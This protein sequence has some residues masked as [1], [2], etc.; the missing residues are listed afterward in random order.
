M[1]NLVLSNIRQRPTRTLISTSGVALGV[2]LIILNTGL[3]RGLLNDRIRREQGV[4]AEIQFF[5]MGG[6]GT[7]SAS[8]AMPLDV[9]YADRLKKIPGVKM[10]SPFGHYLQTGNTGLGFEMVDAID[11]DTYSG[12]SGMGIVEGRA[13]QSDDEVIIDRFK[14]QRSKLGVGSPIQVFGK[15]LRVSGIYGPEIGSRI[16]MSLG[17]LQRALSQENKCLGILIKVDDGV[18]PEEVARRINAELPGNKVV[19]TSDIGANF[20]GQIPGVKGFVRAVMGLSMVVSSLVILLAMYTTITERTREIGILK[21]LGASKTYIIGVIEKEAIAISLIGIVAGLVVALIAGFGIEQ[22]TTLKL[23]F[24]WT[25]ILTAALIGLSAG[26]VG[27]LYPAVRAA[28][29]DAVKAL[30]YE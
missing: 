5:R 24:H 15:T 22:A 23:E 28:N 9:R 11:L 19:L 14:A 17:A 25:W 18:A 1:D 30:S 13:F 21:S 7:L 20:S 10:L 2:I 12:I 8:N 6:G 26:A 27:A 16:K 4:G 3:A 29:Q